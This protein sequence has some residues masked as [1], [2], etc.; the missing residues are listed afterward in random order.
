MPMGMV[1]QSGPRPKPRAVSAKSTPVAMEKPAVESSRICATRPPTIQAMGAKSSL[2]R[3]G[4]PLRRAEI[5]VPS[6]RSARPEAMI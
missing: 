6:A 3:A 2:L 1:C 4:K 5:S